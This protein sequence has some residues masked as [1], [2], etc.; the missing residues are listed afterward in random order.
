MVRDEQGCRSALNSVKKSA[1]LSKSI[2]SSQITLHV[3]DRMVVNGCDTRISGH[4]WNI[5]VHSYWETAKSA[6]ISMKIK[7]HIYHILSSS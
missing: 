7:Q 3:M 1:W 2:G 5:H 6:S 4:A